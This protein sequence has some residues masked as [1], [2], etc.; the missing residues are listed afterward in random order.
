MFDYTSVTA[1]MTELTPDRF[2]YFPLLTLPKAYYYVLFYK[3]C[4]ESVVS[5][6]VIKNA[7]CYSTYWIATLK[8][9]I[10]MNIFGGITNNSLDNCQLKHYYCIKKMLKRAY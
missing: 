3:N 2:I 10:K 9:V 5:K 8:C 4:A 6:A 1:L 7:R